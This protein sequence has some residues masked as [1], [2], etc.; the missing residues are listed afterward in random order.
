MLAASCGEAPPKDPKVEVTEKPAVK[1]TVLLRSGWQS[2]NIGDI[3]HTPGLLRFL[4]QYLAEADV[5]LWSNAVDRG[6]EAMLK[7]HFPKVRIVQG[8]MAEDGTPNSPT[9]AAAF[10]QANFLLHGSGPSV[11]ARQHVEAWRK[12]TGKP[13]GIFGVTVTL[14]SEAASPAIDPAL[15]DLLEHAEFVYTRETTSLKN[16]R[17]VG[18]E[19][20]RYAF[21]PDATFNLKIH[22]EERAKAFMAKYELEPKK[23]IAVVPRLRYTPYQKFKKVNW[24]EERIR[25][26]TAVNQRTAESDHAMFRDAITRWVRETGMKV[27]LCPEMTYQLDIIDPLLYLPLPNDVKK[28]V[29]RRLKYWL[30]DEAASVYRR[31]VT[32][33]SFECHSPIIGAVNDTP[34]VYVH[35]PEDGIKGQMWKDVGLTHW[36]LEA[37][38][39]SGKQ[40]AE[41]LVEIHQKYP[42]A[43]VHTHEAVIYARSLQSAAIDRLR[44]LLIG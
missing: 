33:L 2:E 32:V 29:V 31:A 38:E 40:I 3:A 13:Y 7:R 4:Q 21:A 24:S 6:V 19:G 14:E 36:Y 42:T 11:V 34:P 18:L 22:D 12:Q 26:R 5:I 43:Q 17:A 25:E 20:E 39:T 23:F 37:E 1:P 15:R 30:P 28:N 35:Q 16:L 41:R 44:K 27:L 9:V 10:E 8:G